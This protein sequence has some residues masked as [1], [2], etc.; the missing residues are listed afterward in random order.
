VDEVLAVGDAS[1]QQ[2][3]VRKMED[4]SR[5]GRTVLFVS[6]SMGV[7]SS[8]CQNAIWLK[9]GTIYRQGPARDIVQQYLLNAASPSASLVDLSDTPRNGDDG[10]RLLIT[11]IQWLSGFPL[12]HG[13]NARIK[14]QR[15]GKARA[16][17]R[18]P[19]IRFLDFRKH[20]PVELRF[21]FL[22]TPPDQLE[23]RRHRGRRVRHSRAA[24]GPG[25]YTM[26]IGARSGDFNCLDY[27]RGVVQFDVSPVQTH[28]GISSA[29]P[30]D[31]GFPPA[32]RG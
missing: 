30:A 23:S 28:P 25:T 31:H 6:H 11:S 13:V 18:F 2:K 19:R 21:G 12:Q 22:G 20:A 15:Q 5:G 32:Y 27:L 10:S 24:A 26:D 1:F 16:P 3:C 4:A 9:S 8:L 7:V 29:T 17:G 14:N